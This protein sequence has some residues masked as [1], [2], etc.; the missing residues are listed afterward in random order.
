VST[1]NA[2]NNPYQ[3]V[4]VL[5]T[6][7]EAPLPG[8]SAQRRMS[9]PHRTYYPDRGVQ[10]RTSAV[11]ILI[12]PTS[13]GIFI[14]FT[15]RLKTLAHHGGE[16]SLPGGGVEDCDLSLSHTALRESAEELGLDQAS[17]HIL[18]ALT[19]I[20]IS[21][22]QNMVHPIIGWADSRP[23]F[24]PS[25]YEVERVIEVP[26]KTLLEPGNVR[27]CL[28]HNNGQTHTVPC[29]CINSDYIWGAT[30]MILSEFL[31]IITTHI[32]SVE[33]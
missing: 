14:P 30:A 16:I 9:P 26:I 13:H 4:N 12:Y 11:L 6:A 15:L 32:L 25:P 20:Y 8:I 2:I 27:D 7:L 19:P 17:V 21:A 18:G 1:N 28:L 29:Y 31:C 3:F 24:D 10:T 22:S 5:K 33:Q 23:T